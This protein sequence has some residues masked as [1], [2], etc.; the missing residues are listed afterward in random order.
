MGADQPPP[1]CGIPGKV[2][3]ERGVNGRKIWRASSNG[4]DWPTQAV[5]EPVKV[6]EI[7]PADGD[8]IQQHGAHSV[9]EG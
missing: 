7:E 5:V 8:P 2:L 4:N 9:E 1:R 6:D 3:P